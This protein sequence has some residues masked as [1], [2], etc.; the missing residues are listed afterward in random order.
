M[1]SVT[2]GILGSV[3]IFP[4]VVLYAITQRQFF[5]SNFFILLVAITPWVCFAMLDE[6]IKNFDMVRSLFA[7]LNVLILFFLVPN[8]PNHEV[9]SLKNSAAIVLVL[10][11]VAGILQS[12]QSLQIFHEFINILVPRALSTLGETF[13]IGARGVSG[14]S[15]EPARQAMSIIFLLLIQFCNIRP[16]QGLWSITIISILYLWF[17]NKSAIGTIFSLVFIGGLIAALL[18]QKV[19][20]KRFTFFSVIVVTLFIGLMNFNNFVTTYEKELSKSRAGSLIILASDYNLNELLE[21][22]LD[23]GGFRI[24]SILAIYKDPTLLGYG[25][26]NSAKATGALIKQDKDLIS[27]R[28]YANPNTPVNNRPTS[29]ISALLVEFGLIG[30]FLIFLLILITISNNNNT[31]TLYKFLLLLPIFFSLLIT[32]ASGNPLPIAS[33]LLILRKV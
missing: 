16:N 18:V 26:G 20:F 10:T 33:L 1:P 25:L 4:W 15:S 31:F 28:Y 27:S 23:F 22:G 8:L 14:L 17:I 21:F 3:E 29:F 2:F 5:S 32:G 11:I 30:T 24:S 12:F 19:N 6:G 9:D 13:G 7:Y